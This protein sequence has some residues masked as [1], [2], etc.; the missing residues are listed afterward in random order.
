[1]DYALDPRLIRSFLMVARIGSV[2]A[3]AV[4]LHL[5]QPALSQHL[6]QFSALLQTTL[7]DRVGRR[8][9]LTEAW[10]SL[11][12]ELDPLMET[13]GDVLMRAGRSG[14]ELVE[15]LRI[16]AIHSYVQGVVIPAVE[17]LAAS[18]PRL[19][20]EIRE[21]SARDVDRALLD[22]VI[23]VGIAFSSDRMKRLEER[24]LFRDTLALVASASVASRLTTPV[25]IAQLASLPLA[26]LSS[27]FAMR[28]QIDAA[29][30]RAG[31]R[32]R[33]QVEGPSVDALL[34]LVAGGRFVTI[35][36]P[37][38]TRSR[39]GL[40][41]LPLRGPGFERTAAVRLRRGKTPTRGV[42]ALLAA[43]MKVD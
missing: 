28:S 35:A 22:G 42:H 29:A 12:A 34:G 31:L 23:D 24:A 30:A 20:I 15:H 26:L 27:G 14:T 9:E 21:L 41:A 13:L 33:P 19:T 25:S 3:A 10:R 6:K 36:S 17:R 8:L 37:I 43:V 18:H 11:Y 1:M 40:V 5:T 7:F 32:L 4:E 38:S 16:G 39:P 2:S